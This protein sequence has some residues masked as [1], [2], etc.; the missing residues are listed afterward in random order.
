[1][2][3]E[4]S[5][6]EGGE[7]REGRIRAYH[8][9]LAN[10]LQ[11]KPDFAAV[12]AYGQIGGER[13]HLLYSGNDFIGLDV[14]HTQFRRKARRHESIPAVRPK[15]NHSRSIGYL[16]SADL[17]HL[18]GIDHRDVILTADCDPEL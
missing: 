15:Q 10:V 18:P 7:N 2:V 4:R 13:T 16:Y 6:V 11:R 14:N 1:M 3:R 5:R 9:G 17:L 8:L 12:G